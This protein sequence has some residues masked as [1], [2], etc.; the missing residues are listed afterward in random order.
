[1]DI[2]A[3]DWSRGK[4][5][6]AM[7]TVALVKKNGVVAIAADTHASFGKSHSLPLAAPPVEELEL[8]LKM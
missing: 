4:E 1:V 3:R 2:A 6:L 5:E 8:L 7:S